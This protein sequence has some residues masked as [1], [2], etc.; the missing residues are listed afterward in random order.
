M[1]AGSTNPAPCVTWHNHLA[2]GRRQMTVTKVA[3]A[4]DR[5]R[6]LRAAR[7]E[8]LRGL[9]EVSSLRPVRTCGRGMMTGTVSLK[10]TAQPSGCVA[11]FAGVV[12][13]G[14]VWACPV[15]SAKI[16]AHRQGEVERFLGA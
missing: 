15:C 4:P 9:W 8:A 2:T 14:S 11:G 5:R 12:H 16:S 1:G 3:P 6:E 10:V 13:C 7:W